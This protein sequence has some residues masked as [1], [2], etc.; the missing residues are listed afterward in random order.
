MKK[1]LC[2]F[3]LLTSL[4]SAAPKEI[5]LNRYELS[6]Y[7]QNGEDGVLAKIFELITPSCRYFVDFGSYDGMTGSNSYILRRQGWLGLL[8]DR[9]FD[10]P[11][12]NLHKEFITAE[13]INDLF[14]KYD[15][16]HSFGLLSI[17]IDYNDFYVWQAIDKKYRPAV[18]V[19]EYNAAHLPEEDK[20]VKYRPYFCGDGTTYFGASIRALYNLGRSKGYSL[21]YAEKSGTNL[22]FIRDDILRE[23]NLSFKGMNNL[24]MIYRPATYEASPIGAHRV[25]TKNRPYLSSTDLIEK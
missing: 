17:D 2:I 1:L 14:E 20:V 19:I 12:Y 5:D 21:V 22:F 7:S 15:V 8:L 25:D 11:E 6:L 3:T 18:V 16:P 9:M 4:L 13:N 10:A 23:K 24:E